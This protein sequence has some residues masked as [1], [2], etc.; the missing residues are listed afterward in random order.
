[1]VSTSFA[2]EAPLSADR[3][4]CSKRHAYLRL[5]DGQE[6]PHSGWAGLAKQ[7]PGY[8]QARAFSLPCRTPLGPAAGLASDGASHR[9]AT[10]SGGAWCVGVD[11]MHRLLVS[12]DSRLTTQGFMPDTCYFGPDESALC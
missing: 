7:L 6:G 1:M 4:I 10:R 9:A 2:C 3:I 11:L 8:G 5:P 12:G